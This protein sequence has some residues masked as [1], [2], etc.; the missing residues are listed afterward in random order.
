MQYTKNLH[1]S[2]VHSLHLGKAMIV[3]EDLIHVGNVLPSRG[4][5]EW[6]TIFSPKQSLEVCTLYILS[7]VLVSW[8]ACLSVLNQNN[9]MKHFAV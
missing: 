2:F 8:H 4:P 6:I 9:V 1:R 7:P 3:V 5:L